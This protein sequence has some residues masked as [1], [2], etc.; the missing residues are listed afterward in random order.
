[1]KLLTIVFTFL[2]LAGCTINVTYPEA[3]VN[4]TPIIV[5]VPEPE[6]VVEE[7]IV[8]KYCDNQALDKLYFLTPP[9][10]QAFQKR[11]DPKGYIVAMDR[12]ITDVQE[13]IVDAKFEQLACKAK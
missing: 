9:D 5:N 2:F 3:P 8:T 11:N 1:M 13:Y 6:R 7:K 4:E 12:Y 10:R